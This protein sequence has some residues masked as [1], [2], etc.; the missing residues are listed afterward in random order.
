LLRGFRGLV[1]GKG[2]DVDLTEQGLWP[3]ILLQC[4]RRMYRII[5]LGGVLARK[6]QDDLRAA[7]VVGKEVGDLVRG[8]F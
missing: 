8:T 1:Q 5:L 2:G 7:G 6:P 4:S 3:Q